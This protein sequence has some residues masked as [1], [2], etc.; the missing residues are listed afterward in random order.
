MIN[1]LIVVPFINILVVLYSLIPGH[2][3]GIAVIV[4]TVLI[5]LAL[6]PFASKALHGQ[7]AM[8]EIQPEV[9]KLK[10]KYK[11]NSTEFNKAV[12]ELYKEKEVNPFGS[13]LPSLIQMPFLFGMFYTF[14]KFKNPAFIA[15]GN[16]SGIQSFLYLPV[17]NLSFVKNL[18]A[19]QAVIKTTFL[20]I[21]DLA[22]P[23]VVVALIA[24]ATQFV[25][26]KMM[27]PQKSQDQSQKAMSQMTYLFPGLTF[28]FGLR[29]PAALP[30]YWAVQSGFAVFQQ[31]LVMHRDV[32]FLEHLKS[33]T[34]NTKK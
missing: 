10:K 4:F 2:D 7:K 5:R 23:S 12:M 14:M 24:A 28:V 29:F 9:E 8:Q 18:F 21:L 34:F 30:L 33:V 20:G 13:C 19:S 17:K 15:L 27:T 26:T 22:K 3:F 6:W 31:Y 16:P 25:Q 32:S 11:K 1:N